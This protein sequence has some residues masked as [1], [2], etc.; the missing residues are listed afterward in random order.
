[1]KRTPH[2]QRHAAQRGLTLVEIL[3]ALGISAI[4]LTGALQIFISSKLSYTLSEANARVQEG[5]RF[6]VEFINNDLRMTGYLGCLRSSFTDLENVLADPDHFNWNIGAQLEGYEWTGAG[7]SPALPL[8]IAGKVRD[9]TDVIVTRGVS[10]NGASLIAPFSDGS[11]VFIETADNEIREGDVVAITSCDQGS[12]TVVNSVAANGS[13][14]IL[15][16]DGITNIFGD[17]AEVGRIETSFYYIGTNDADEPALF[18][19]SLVNS[20]GALVMQDQELVD[21]VENLQITYGEDTNGDG[22]ANRYVRAHEATMSEVINVRV[23]LLLRT[24]NNIASS[25]QTYVYDDEKV[26][27]TDL[28]MRRVFNS[29]A[30]LRNRGML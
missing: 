30:K 19:G 29:T 22:I 11:Q 16:H 5:G 25:P 18:R 3:V 7:W 8:E 23:S 28:R 24:D 15:E 1:M 12:I 21:G 20:G 27:A 9:G 2:Q 10:R 13:E 4:L 14:T 17:G 6:A 26:T